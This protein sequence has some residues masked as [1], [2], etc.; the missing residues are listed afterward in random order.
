MEVSE[1]VVRLRELAESRYFSGRETSRAELIGK[2]DYVDA[3]RLASNILGAWSRARSR[4]QRVRAALE[5]RLSM[6]RNRK[7]P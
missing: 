1:I 3:A 5:K 7:K 2:E 4:E 6:E